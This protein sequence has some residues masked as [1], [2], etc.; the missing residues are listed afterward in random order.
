MLKVTTRPDKLVVI[1]WFVI[2]IGL[3]GI[4]AIAVHGHG[5]KT[6]GEESFTAFQALQKAT[7]LYDRL[8]VSGKLK[9]NWETGL[10]RVS[11]DIRNSNNKRE[12]VVQFEKSEGEP[13]SVYF[14]FD[15]EG[16][17]SGSNFSGK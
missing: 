1:I 8:I 7:E 3:N 10:K 16:K 15:Q 11:I 17:Y 13:N 14:Y 9:E 6:H 12:Y 4:F 5:G 2:A